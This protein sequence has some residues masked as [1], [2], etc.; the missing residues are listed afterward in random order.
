[1]KTYHQ[2][3]IGIFSENLEIQNISALGRA[4][5]ACF[6]TLNI[7]ILQSLW[8]MDLKIDEYLNIQ[9]SYKIL[10]LKTLLVVSIFNIAA[11]FY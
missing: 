11:F 9:I 3:S 6:S 10:Q 5:K 2:I 4:E 1:M 7:I 8:W